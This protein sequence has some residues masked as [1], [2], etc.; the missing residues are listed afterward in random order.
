M[1]GSPS[2]AAGCS[3]PAHRCTCGTQRSASRAALAEQASHA[4]RPAGSSPVGHAAQ[5]LRGR[6]GG[7]EADQHTARDASRRRC[8]PRGPGPAMRVRL[9]P[10]RT[11]HQPMHSPP[12]VGGWT[13]SCVCESVRAGLLAPRAPLPQHWPPPP[14]PVLPPGR[15]RPPARHAPGSVQPPSPLPEGMPTMVPLPLPAGGAA[16]GQ[17][18]SRGRAQ[19]DSCVAARGAAPR[20]GEGPAWCPLPCGR[21]GA[22]LTPDLDVE[23]GGQGQRV[24]LALAHVRLGPGLDAVV[25]LRPV[26]RGAAGAGGPTAGA[27]GY[28]AGCR[29]ARAAAP[30]GPAA[31][32]ATAG[33]SARASGAG[34]QSRLTSS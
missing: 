12:A 9:Q 19:P 10:R 8:W 20:G 1:G 30:P 28:A 15:A 4:G 5:R 24:D 22:A 14:P 29:G 32:L 7:R 27:G 26:L 2:P 23:G 16:S 34:G 33:H 13:G 3:R 31:A 11:W 25:A 17:G 21:G 18:M 6:A